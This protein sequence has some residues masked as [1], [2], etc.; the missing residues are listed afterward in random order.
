M[1]PMPVLLLYIA[2]P[3][4]LLLLVAP[5]GTAAATCLAQPIANGSRPGGDYANH[6]VTGAANASHA[7]ELCRAV[8]CA[9]ERCDFWG[10]DVA[11]PTKGKVMNCSHGQMCCWQKSAK[12]VSRPSGQCAWGCLTEARAQALK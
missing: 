2:V 7:A 9:D 3:L 8:C 12:G 1:M 11:L 4:S 10:L 5:V 6:P